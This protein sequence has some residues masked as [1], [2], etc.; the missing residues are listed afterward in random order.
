MY[1]VQWVDPDIG[2][3]GDDMAGCDSLLNLGYGYNGGE[4]GLDP[5]Y[6]YIMHLPTPGI[7]YAL[8]KGP[9]TS[10][11]SKNLPMTSCM[12]HTTGP[13][14][15][16]LTGPP[17]G[18]HVYRYWDF[19]RGCVPQYGLYGPASY[20]L[21]VDHER[22]PT[23]YMYYGDPVTRTGWIAARPTYYWYEN[24]SLP[25]FHGGDVRFYMGTGPFTM[26]LGDTQ[27]VVLAVVSSAMSSSGENVKWLKVLGKFLQA[28]YPDLGEY[29]AGNLTTIPDRSNVPSEFKLEQNFPNPFNPSTQIRFS[30]PIA[31]PVK[32]SVFDMLGR[33]IRVLY[34]GFLDAGQHQV[35]W[36]GCD[37]SGRALPSGVYVNRLTQGSRQESRKMILLR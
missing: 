17:S 18:V 31:G 36:D 21:P 25:D 24:P 26:A 29:V 9:L 13:P 34:A 12:V 16:Q 4:S 15:D 27:E 7:G 8:L 20:T 11:G 2:D 35:T 30:V 28:V 33:E 37:A 14:G 32:L 10:G 3:A 23:R 6:N 19:A 1:L 22:K 5:V